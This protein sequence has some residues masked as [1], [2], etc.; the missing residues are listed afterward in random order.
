MQRVP[1]PELMDELEQA[2]AYAAADF[3]DVNRAFAERFLDG[4][5]GLR[6]GRILDLGCG[7]A[8]ILLRLARALPGARFVGVD[9]AA[10]MLAEGERAVAEA[11]LGHAITLERRILPDLP[12]GRFDAV[13]SNSLLHHLHDPMVLWRAVRAAG[14]PGA[15]VLVVDLF[16]PD[17][18]AEA[19]AIV[20]T[21]AADEPPVLKQDFFNSL[22]AAFTFDEVR[23]QLDRAGLGDLGVRVISERH[24]AVFGRLRSA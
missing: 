11:G 4:F 24:L 8:D 6:A 16:R 17:S 2:A 12:P 15:P 7:P 5:P 22:L 23:A 14:R 18:E 20:E 10:A 3:E 19:R 21:H 9:G 13:L 1:E